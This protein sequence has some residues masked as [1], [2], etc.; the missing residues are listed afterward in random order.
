MTLG[1]T[2]P[3]STESALG[4]GESQ[5]RQE[6]VWPGSM[7]GRKERCPENGKVAVGVCASS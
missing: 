1:Q 4:A 3:E 7:L 2:T 5:K 6:S